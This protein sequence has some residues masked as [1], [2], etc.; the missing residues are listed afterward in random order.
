MAFLGQSKDK[1]TL[2]LDEIDLKS[3]EQTEVSRSL[4][5]AAPAAVAVMVCFVVLGNF[6]LSPTSDVELAQV[7]DKPEVIMPKQVTHKTPRQRPKNYEP[8]QRKPAS[9]QPMPR[10]ERS[11]LTNAPTIHSEPYRTEEPQYNEPDPM[12]DPVSEAEQN[13]AQDNGQE[14]SLV[15]NSPLPHEQTPPQAGDS[16]D[17]AMN[18]AEAPLEAPVVEEASDF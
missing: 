5:W 18:G 16:L 1:P 6:L 9:Y 8:A 15:N 10:Y 14:H 12:I 13:P 11:A 7:S 2:N 17:H 4:K 3:L